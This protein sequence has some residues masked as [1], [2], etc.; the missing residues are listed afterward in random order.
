[1]RVGDCE[2]DEGEVMRVRVDEGE[3]PGDEAEDSAMQSAVRSVLRRMVAAHISINQ[4]MMYD[5]Q[6]RTGPN[7]LAGMA[8]S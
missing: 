6:S 5:A 7:L 2:V 4:S 8:T 3:A 1:M